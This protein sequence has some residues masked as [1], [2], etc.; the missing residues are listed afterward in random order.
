MTR[1]VAELTVKELSEPRSLQSSPRG[2]GKNSSRLP[3]DMTPGILKEK[4]AQGMPRGESLHLRCHHSAMVGKRVRAEWAD[5]VQKGANTF[6]GTPR[7]PEGR[8]VGARTLRLLRGVVDFEQ[9]SIL[10]RTSNIICWASAK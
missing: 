1:R 5:Y 9:G 6:S 4:T 2:L 3:L 7:S 10:S 8:P